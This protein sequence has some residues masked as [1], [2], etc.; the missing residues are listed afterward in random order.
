MTYFVC[1]MRCCVCALRNVFMCINT[2]PELCG[3]S[4]YDQVLIV[5]KF[6]IQVNDMEGVQSV[7]LKH[8][9]FILSFKI[10]TLL[11][12]TSLNLNLLFSFYVNL[13]SVIYYSFSLLFLSFLFSFTVFYIKISSK[14][15][16]VFLSYD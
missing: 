1:V 6:L 14:C 12:F 16:N 7:S 15:K 13:L 9:R 8:F 3:P 11:A 10:N 5:I 2:R 4:Y